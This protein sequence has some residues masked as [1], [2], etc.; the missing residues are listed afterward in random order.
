[1]HRLIPALASHGTTLLLGFALGIY[2]LPILTAPDSP[3][4]TSLVQ[5]QNTALYTATL[6]R[7]LRGSDP[8]H[9]GEGTLYVKD[10]TIALMGKLAPGPDYRLYLS[11][12]F[13]DD[14]AGFLRH[15]ADMVQIGH[16]RTFNDFLVDVPQGIDVSAFNTVIVWCESFGQFITAAQYQGLPQLAPG[17]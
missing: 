14:R 17:H 9:W 11:P 6:R 5:V 7:D 12:R 15:K 13:V 10:D 4:T 16:I 2:L 8:L 1:M 3:A